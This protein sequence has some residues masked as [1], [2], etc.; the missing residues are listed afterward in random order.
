[1]SKARDVYNEYYSFCKPWQVDN[2]VKELES[3]KASL[4]NE[5][6]DLNLKIIGFE[7]YIKEREGR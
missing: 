2:Y 1:M 5:I 6:M 7:E 3:E 4:Q